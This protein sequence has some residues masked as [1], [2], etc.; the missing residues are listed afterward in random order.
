MKNRRQYDLRRKKTCYIHSNDTKK[1][2]IRKKKV[3]DKETHPSE[4]CS[5]YSCAIP[6]VFFSAFAQCSIHL[7]FTRIRMN[8]AGICFEFCRVHIIGAMLLMMMMMVMTIGE[9]KTWSMYSIQS[10]NLNRIIF[11]FRF[12]FTE[13]YLLSF[14]RSVNKFRVDR[15]EWRQFSD[16][17]RKK[18]K[19]ESEI[20]TKLNE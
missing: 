8:R 15:F 16:D 20:Q 13:S 3:A 2:K 11:V 17:E 9:Y 12:R 5:L 4:W 14:V 7:L 6:F 19:K 10:R 18:K 1:M